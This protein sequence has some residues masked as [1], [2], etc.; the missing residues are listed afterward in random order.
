MGGERHR[1][2]LNEAPERLHRKLQGRKA[3][4]GGGGVNGPAAVVEGTSAQ[5]RL[6][7]G[8]RAVIT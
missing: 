4:R 8:E 7:G 3:K 6:N 2:R 1:G 5:T